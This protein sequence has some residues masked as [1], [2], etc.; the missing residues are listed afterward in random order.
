MK[1]KGGRQ[2]SGGPCLIHRVVAIG[3]VSPMSLPQ[4]SSGRFDVIM[5]ERF[6]Y[7]RMMISKRYSPERLGSCFMPMS[8]LMTRSG[9]R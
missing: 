7:R 9:F 3:E 6:S 5:V 1:N 8:S 4:S 2:G